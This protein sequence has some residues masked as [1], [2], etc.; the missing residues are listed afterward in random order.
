MSV[1]Q[2]FHRVPFLFLF[3][4][5]TFSYAQKLESFV[6]CSTI[7]H[8]GENTPLWQVSNQQGLSSINNNT[9]FR[10]GAFYKDTIRSWKIEGGV[11][12]AVATGFTSTFVV[13]QAYADIRYKW[14]GLWAGNRELN[15][16]LLNQC[17]SSGGLT[18][19]GNARPL[20][21]I[22][23]GIFDYIH[24]TPRVQ[25]KAELSYG[26]FTDTKYQEENVGEEDSY[27]RKIKYHHKSF[28]FRFGKPQGK[29]LFDL[30]MSLDTQFGGYKIRGADEGDLGNGWRDYW[31][32]FFPQGGGN[33]SPGGEQIWYQ[34]NYLG[35]E[36]LK[37]TYQ[38]NKFSL[39]VYLENFYDDFS[40]MGKLNGMD[41]LWGIEY[42]ANNPQ[43]I[44]GIVL[45]YYQTTN[46]SGPLHGIDY[47]IVKKTGGADD[48]YNSTWYPGW[49]HWG[50][51]MANPLV[52]S[53]IYNKNG[54]L[55]FRYNRV[56]AVHLG[57]SGD[58]SKEWTYRAKLSFNRTWGTPHEPIP[59][60]LENFST[61]A[62]FKYVP[63]KWQGWS[64]TGSAAFDIGDIYGDNLGFQLKIHKSF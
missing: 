30:G 4:I 1:K 13:Q 12:L 21:Q 28:F 39:S 8:G 14:I 5:G 25:V 23:I 40:G 35:S 48:Y 3:L 31:N 6:E 22:A 51:T 45:E 27:T 53:P 36:H 10:G 2:V 15:S 43:V 11:D 59:E 61:F 41:G 49:V 46:Q 64:F 62:E 55:G 38:L 26:W 60:I 16:P 57:W 37:L 50:M 47:S 24:V 19:S 20:P 54:N 42:K 18:W 56:K 7:I 52:A 58:I 33:D 63:N 32:V 44:N 29:W 17:L 9:Y 34:G